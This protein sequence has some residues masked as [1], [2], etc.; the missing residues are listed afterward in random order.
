MIDVQ[1][2]SDHRELPIDMVGVKGVRCPVTVLDRARGRQNTVATISVFVDL[3]QHFKGTHMSRFIELLNEHRGSIDI[4][5]FGRILEQ[6]KSRLE[7]RSASIELHFPYFITKKAPISGLEAPMDYDVIY[8]GRIDEQDRQTLSLCVKVPIAT[9]CPCSREISDRGAH[10]QRGVVTLSLRVKRF[11]WLEDLIQMVEKAGSGELYALLKREDEK[12]CTE[13]AYD[14]P[15][16]TEDVVREIGAQLRDDAN[17]VWFKV[18]SE[19]IESIHNHNA[20]ACIE[21]DK[22]LHPTPKA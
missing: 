17:V 22:D 19:T 8:R 15:R 14:H 4:R 6:V 20:Y 12:Y 18:E 21:M 13:S 9:V 7:A 10:N 3:P 2:Q 5:E 16:F 1:N 11:V